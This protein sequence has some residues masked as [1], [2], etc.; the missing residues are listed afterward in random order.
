LIFTASSIYSLDSEGTV[1][2]IPGA[3]HVGNTPLD[4]AKG[5]IPIRNEMIVLGANALFLVLDTRFAGQAACRS[6]G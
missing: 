1:T 5:V 6:P 4:H 2:E 3:R